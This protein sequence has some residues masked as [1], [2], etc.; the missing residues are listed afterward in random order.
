MLETVRPEPLRSPVLD[1]FAS[2]GIRHGF[3]TRRGGVSDGIYAGLNVGTGSNDEPGHVAENRRRIAGW[4][5]TTPDRLVTVHQ[6]H[7]PHAV[8]VDAPFAGERPKAD[9]MVTDQPGL[10]LAVL[11]A[12][13]GP[14]LYADPQARVI[15]AAHAGWQG[16]LTGVLEATVE[17]ME[18]LGARRER[19]AAVLGPSIGRDNY[20]VGPEFF[21]RFE[22]ANPAN[23]AYFASSV[24]PGHFMFDLNGY[25]IDRL[26]AAGVAAY[27]IDRCTYADEALFFSY[28]R[29]THRAEPDYGRQISAIVLEDI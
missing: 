13:C 2:K 23:A 11:A 22:A 8:V 9:A 14:V 5:G 20:E 12:D 1:D 28:R 17:A 6:V 18:R 29:T 16:A 3:F 4:M 24:K 21:A 25:T 7:S 10:A 26:S 15:G 19:I 27:G